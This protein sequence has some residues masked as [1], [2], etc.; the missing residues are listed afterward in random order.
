MRYY[1][2]AL[3]LALASIVSAT[4]YYI[5]ASGD[6]AVNTGLSPSSP[7][8]SISKVNSVFPSLKPGDKILF[9]RGDRF[10][11]TINI[12]KS[13]TAGAPITIGAY[14]TGD[15]PVITGFKTASDWTNVSGVTYSA[16]LTSVALT[17][18]VTIDGIQYYM[19]RWPDNKYNIFESA[20]GNLSI[21][22]NELGMTND[23]TGAE[24]VIRKNDHALDR[25]KITNHSGNTLNY[26]SLSTSQEAFPGHGYFIQNDLRTLSLQGEW[27]HDTV[28][29]RIYINFGNLTPSDKKVEIATLNYLVYNS[30]YDYIVLDNLHLTGSIS[31]AVNFIN[32]TDYTS[33]KSCQINFAGQ[34]G[35]HLWGE[36]CNLENNII[37]NCNQ[38]GIQTVGNYETIIS[39]IIRNIGAIPGQALAGTYANGIHITN[40]N[41][42]IKNNTIENIGYCGITLSSIADIITIQNNF[43][44]NV[45]IT[46]NDGGGIYTAGEGISRK[47]D[48]NIILNVRGVTEGTPYPTQYI[49]R[50]IYLDVGSSNV[51]VTN[52]TVA[53]CSEGAYMIHRASGNQFENNT[54]FNNGYGM[55]F[56]NT[57]GS[58]IRNNILKNNLFIAKGSTQLAL[59]F[60][61]VADDIPS[62]GTADNNYY[63]RPVDDDDVFHTY[64]PSTGSKYRILADWQSFTSQDRNSKKSPVSVSDT[65]KIDFYY[66]P[67]TS[68]KVISLAQPMIDVKGIKYSGSVTLLP[69]ASVILMPDPNPTQPAMPSFSGAVVENSSPS[70][71]TLTFSIALAAIVPAATSFTVK[72]NGIN[73]NVTSVAVSGSNVNLTL[74]SAAKNGDIITISYIKPSAN[75]LQTTA[76]GQAVSFTSMSVSNNCAALPNKPPVV[77]IAYPSKGSSFTSPA[78]FTIDVVAADPDG[79][80]IKV[81]LFNGTVKLEERITPPYHF[82]LKELDAGEYSLHAVATDNLQSSASSAALEFRVNPPEERRESFCLFPN[83]N[84]GLFSIKF[85]TLTETG[86]NFN[87]RIVDLIGNTVYIQDLPE[88]ESERQFDLSQLKSGVYFLI[89][90]AGQ[91]ITAQKFIKH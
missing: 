22:D 78:S 69:Y 17:N 80:I 44:N 13:G 42:L 84:E 71:M 91:I 86:G 38:A 43:I 66:N 54:A 58:S 83:P 88:G 34:D 28:N 53:N 6:D 41:C 24:V 55:F 18:M 21:T 15:K 9:N 62:F 36:N 63:T 25:C 35:V 23:W 10:Y 3:L 37:T 49:A 19:G 79:A 76:G 85:T 82:T 12:G 64:S 8:R 45:L 81:E 4:D 16:P 7:W 73:V 14:G 47:I 39:N 72:V 65:S 57:S 29:A 27:F 59:K 68:N 89:L 61:S 5:S 2:A 74:A 20:S 1:F 40:N 48:G 32:S 11:G 67:S 33:I 70:S 90:S 51:S 56:Q 87:V 30:G 77:S 46:L 75:P 60:Y 26:R 31:H 50:G 52:N